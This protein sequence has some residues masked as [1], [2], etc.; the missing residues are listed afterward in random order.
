MNNVHK[1]SNRGT[2]RGA[3]FALVAG[4]AARPPKNCAPGP[5]RLSGRRPA[6]ATRHPQKV[7][8]RATSPDRPEILDN[9]D[10][11][12]RGTKPL[13]CG[14]M[15]PT[16]GLE[17]MTPALRVGIKDQTIFIR[18]RTAGYRSSH[19]PNSRRASKRN[20]F[21]Q[22]RIPRIPE[23]LDNGCPRAPGFSGNEGRGRRITGRPSAPHRG[24]RGGAG[25]VR[26]A[27][28]ARRTARQTLA[29]IKNRTK[30]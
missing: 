12:A 1:S 13:A 28:R 30:R 22:T 17:P 7:A 5:G 20:P 16:M 24:P 25:P 19:K 11:K 21:M 10:Q 2:A 15:E 27:P 4:P 6:R 23:P 18:M 8:R 29:R 26:P 3:G 14:S 9:R